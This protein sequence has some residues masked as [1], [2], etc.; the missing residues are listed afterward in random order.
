MIFSQVEAD[1]IEVIFIRGQFQFSHLPTLSET[2][3]ILVPCRTFMCLVVHIIRHLL[4]CGG[5]I[6]LSKH[7]LEILKGNF[8]EYTTYNRLTEFINHEVIVAT[9][10]FW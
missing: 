4:H 7:L 1:I 3:L 5:I 2:L 9:E 10:N 8:L 6:S